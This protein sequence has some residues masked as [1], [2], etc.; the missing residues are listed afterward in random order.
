VQAAP[1]SFIR[2]ADKVFSARFMTPTALQE[3]PPEDASASAIRHNFHTLVQAV[4]MLQNGIRALLPPSLLSGGHDP[5]VSL[6]IAFIRLFQQLLERLNRFGDKRIDFYYQRVLGMRPQP[7]KPDSAFL[8]IRPTA[9]AR[10]IQIDAG[11]EFIGGVDENQEDII[12]AADSAATL[13]DAHVSAL[14]SLYF[15]RRPVMGTTGS[16]HRRLELLQLDGDERE[17]ERCRPS[18]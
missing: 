2:I 15:E 12:Y 8:V 1:P 18:R 14:H 6:L 9:A 13:N 3:M 17:H 10:Q 7:Q 5:G 16:Y 4:R 11:A